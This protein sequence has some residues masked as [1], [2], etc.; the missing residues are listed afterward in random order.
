MTEAG[1]VSGGARRALFLALTGMCTA[2]LASGCDGSKGNLHAVPHAVLRGHTR[3]LIA[4]AFSQDGNFIV[5]A[6]ADKTARVWDARS[7]KSLAVLH[8]TNRVVKA[9]FSPDGKRIV[10]TSWDHTARLWDARSR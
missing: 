7:G 5:T 1:V 4:A 9:V 6:S 3:A 2:V 10:T 8:H